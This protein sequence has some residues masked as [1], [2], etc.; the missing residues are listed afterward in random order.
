MPLQCMQSFTLFYTHNAKS[1]AS[2]NSFKMLQVEW[3]RQ[4]SSAFSMLKMLKVEWCGNMRKWC[5]TMCGKLLADRW[6]PSEKKP[7]VLLRLCGCMG[8]SKRSW[9]GRR[10]QQ[11]ADSAVKTFK[12]WL[13]FSDKTDMAH[14]WQNF[15]CACVHTGRTTWHVSLPQ[16]I[17]VGKVCNKW[18]PKVTKD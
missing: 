13:R 11:V 6:A 9:A 10:S 15:F 4:K 5:G 16:R 1:W 12:L 7:A 14:L 2:P 17:G 3:F 18:T 8:F